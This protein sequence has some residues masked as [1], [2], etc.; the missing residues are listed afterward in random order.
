MRDYK[1]FD[2]RRKLFMLRKKIAGNH[3]AGIKY[4][5]SRIL[6]ESQGNE[7]IK[8]LLCSGHPVTISRLGGT[9]LDVVMCKELHCD[10]ERKKILFSQRLGDLS[11]FFPV[12]P[13]MIE[14]YTDVFLESITDIDFLGIWFFVDNEEYMIEKYMNHPM[15]SLHR[16]I[17]PQYFEHPWSKAL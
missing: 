4:A 17:E 1:Y 9:E 11:G 7:A 16:S 14:K 6:T 12:V 8:E 2:R 10:D 13:E 3:M 15:C 5:G